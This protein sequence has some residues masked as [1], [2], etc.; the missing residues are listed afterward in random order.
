MKDVLTKDKF[1]A[2]ITAHL[3]RRKS[4]DVTDLLWK[5]YLAA[6]GEWGFL[7]P[8]DYHDLDDKLKDIGEDERREILLGFPDEYD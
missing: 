4:S 8:D 2:L 5:G 6:L 1:L 7:R 3:E